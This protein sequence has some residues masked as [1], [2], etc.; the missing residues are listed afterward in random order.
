MHNFTKEYLDMKLILTNKKCF[1]PINYS[2]T[3]QPDKAIILGSIYVWYQFFT[4]LSEL[5]M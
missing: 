1:G 2:N 4:N 3:K 5:H